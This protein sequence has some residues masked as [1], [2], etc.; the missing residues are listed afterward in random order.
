MKKG[1]IPL[2]GSSGIWQR[3]YCNPQYLS[4]GV[5]CEYFLLLG[6]LSPFLILCV[7]S[8]SPASVRIHF[9]WI[10]PNKLFSHKQL[11]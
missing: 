7:E 1:H 5:D 3:H 10:S 9:H 4:S 11:D 2:D 6:T 8:E